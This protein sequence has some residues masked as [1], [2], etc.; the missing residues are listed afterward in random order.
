[1]SLQHLLH[2][3]AVR[4]R[5]AVLLVFAATFAA[6]VLVTLTRQEEYDATATLFVGENRP[7]TTGANAVQLDEVLAQTYAELLDTGAVASDVARQLPFPATAEDLSGHFTFEVL[8]GT[9][10]IEITATSEDPELA[11]VL[12]NGYATGFVNRQARSAREDS[13]ATLERL[14]EQMAEVA[15][16]IDQLQGA[17]RLA[18]AE[19]KLAALQRSYE[20]IQEN[21]A[22]QSST[23]AVSTKAVIPTAPARPRT[24]LMLAMGF[25]LAIVA[26]VGAGLLRNTFDKR[27]RDEKELTDLLDAQ[28]LARVPVRPETR[29][30]QRFDESLQFLS[31]NLQ[32]LHPDARVIAVTSPVPSDGKTTI[33]AGL[34]RAFARTGG[35]VIALDCDL[36]RPR[37]AALMG[38]DASRGVTNVLVGSTDPLQLVQQTG[39]PGLEVLPS[40]PLPP[41]PA[42][43]LGTS[44]FE[45]MMAQLRDTVDYVLID[46]PPVT[47]GAETSDAASRVDGVVIVVDLARSNRS[48]LIATRDQLARAGARILGIVLNRSGDGRVDYAYYGYYGG[49]D[50]PRPSTVDGD[51]APAARATTG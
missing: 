46:T 5:N 14:S 48:A 28:V 38:R 3:L 34:G 35:E 42:V 40:G 8:T 10:L 50:D 7:V 12:A 43:L 2:V 39:S 13:R 1:M 45:R 37:L 16:E 6:V 25:V 44:A 11:A 20:T 30:A 24:R 21:V 26:G 4:Q 49:E 19:A 32:L 31:A 51:R 22:L 33:V 18:Q 27:L 9:N 23:L 47:V 29:S 17:G 36:R 15:D 41:N